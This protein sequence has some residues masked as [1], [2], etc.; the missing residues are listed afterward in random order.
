MIMKMEIVNEEELKKEVETE[1]KPQEKQVKEIS[2]LAK[3]NTNEIMD[4]DLENLN[5]K[6]KM[7]KSIDEFAMDT[8]QNSSRKNSLLQTTIG[9]LSKEGEE[10]ST[11]SN[12]LAD[13]HREIK[14]LDPSLINFTEGSF[15]QKIINPIRRYFEK[16][17]KADS[18]IKDILVSLE[19]GQNTLKNDNTTLDIEEGALRELTKK[20]N[21]ELELGMAMD[22]QI[23]ARLEIAKSEGIEEEKYKFVTEE[24]LFPLRQ[25][26]MDMQQMVVVNHQGIVAMEV[27]KRNNREL[28][29]GVDRARTVTVTALRTAVMVAS[30][31]YNQKIVLKKIDALNTTTSN[32]IA[33]TGRML[34]EQ[35]VEVQKQA[36][37][38]TVNP[39]N[40][41][42]AFQDAISALEDIST[43]KQEALPKMHETINQFRELAEVGEKEIA[44]LESADNAEKE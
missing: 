18:V 33:N 17:E 40:L 19:K 6:R 29:R 30:A 35:G 9:N 16:Y 12:S 25:R 24:I 7:I 5:E 43:F 11:V 27:I 38:A 26:I 1:V 13:L 22:E 44:R 31:L 10:G 34:K 21:N 32:I 8:M 41:K 37:S 28:I 3:E 2:N 42:Q 23:T 15:L 36:T 4:L 14:D 39:D 20:L